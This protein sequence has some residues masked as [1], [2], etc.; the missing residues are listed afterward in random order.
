MAKRKLNEHD[1]PEE[2]GASEVSQSDSS[3]PPAF[4]KVTATTTVTAT[5]TATPKKTKSKAKAKAKAPAPAP[6][7]AS[8]A[9]LQLEPRL[10]RAIRD[11]KWASPTAVQAQA[12][13]LALEGRDILARS[14]TGTGKTAAYLLPI[15]HN[16]LQ[17]KQTSLIL[18]PTK[19]LAL[20]V[21]SIIY[22]ITGSD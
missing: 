22:D 4:P 20:Q 9:E 6:I 10:L 1:V 7:A 5:A 11:L 19:E 21:C 12:I 13:P 18:V 8:F 15:L 16:T 14:G 3:S 17:R 2:S